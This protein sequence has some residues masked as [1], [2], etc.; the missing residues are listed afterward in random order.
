MKD[1]L[2]LEFARCLLKRQGDPSEHRPSEINN[3]R[4]KLRCVARLLTLLHPKGTFVPL[5]TYITAGGYDKV[6]D[7]A[8]QLALKSPQLGL[9][10]GHYIKQ[11]CLQKIGLAI[12][13]KCTEDLAEAESFKKLYEASWSSQVA[14]PTS[15]RQRLR[16]L[17]KAVELPLTTDVIKFTDYLKETVDVQLNL[18]QIDIEK[19]I[20]V[21]L[22]SIIMFNKRRPAEVSQLKF[23]DVDSARNRED[24]NL[25]LQNSLTEAEK[26]LAKRFAC[27]LICDIVMKYPI[28]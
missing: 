19:L 23:E 9:S 18:E 3:I 1:S 14:A 12:K 11:I 8:R 7:A 25:E 6:E 4:K 16:Q 20:K 2:I 28:V 21:T 15:R 10:L 13:D 24:D 17:N 26:Q 22:A 5:T 27:H